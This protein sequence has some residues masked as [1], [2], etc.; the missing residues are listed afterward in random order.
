MANAFGCSTFPALRST[1]S[2]S[3]QPDSQCY[4]NQRHE[5]S[6]FTICG[7]DGEQAMHNLCGAFMGDTPAAVF[8]ARTFRHPV[9]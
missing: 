3:I 9:Q 4:F 1:V 5:T 2:S 7:V 8:F 6:T